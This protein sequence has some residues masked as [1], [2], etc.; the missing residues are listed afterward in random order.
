MGALDNA[1]VLVTGSTGEVG[2]GVAHAAQAAGA[3]LLLPTRSASSAEQLAVEFDDALVVTTDVGTEQGATDIAAAVAEAGRLDH[4]VAPLGA[5]WQKGGSLDQDPNELDE[6]LHTYASAQL[7]LLHVT[8]SHLRTTGGSY[9]IVSGAAGEALIPGAGLLVIAVRAQY[10]LSEVLRDECAR[11]S[12]RLN[13][14]RI[15]TRI[16]RAERP[17]VVP[18]LSAGAAF[19]DVMISNARSEVIRFDGT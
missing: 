11:D 17:G 14:L 6:L 7:R 8:A 19:V 18:S 5:W 1:V 2:W 16:E 4:V 15:A 10:A 3:R 9:T 13:E 12:F